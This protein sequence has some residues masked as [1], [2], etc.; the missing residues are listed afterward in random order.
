MINLCLD[1][2][3]FNFAFTA[4]KESDTSVQLPSDITVSQGSLSDQ[5]SVSEVSQLPTSTKTWAQILLERSQLRANSDTETTPRIL[6]EV[7]ISTYNSETVLKNLCFDAT[8]TQ[9]IGHKTISPDDRKTILALSS[10]LGSLHCEPKSSET[11][12]DESKM[13]S[14]GHP[15]DSHS[16]S[17]QVQDSSEGSSLANSELPSTN[18]FTKEL[19]QNHKELS[20]F[21]SRIIQ[22]SKTFHSEILQQSPQALPLDATDQ[23]LQNSTRISSPHVSTMVSLSPHC[24][25]QKDFTLVLHPSTV[26]DTNASA[27]GELT[28][29]ALFQL[30]STTNQSIMGHGPTLSACSPSIVDN[31]ANMTS[32]SPADADSKTNSSDASLISVIPQTLGAQAIT[33]S[34]TVDVSKTVKQSSLSPITVNSPLPFQPNYQANATSSVR[35]TANLK[36]N[37]FSETFFSLYHPPKEVLSCYKAAAFSV[38][39]EQTQDEVINMRT[40]SQAFIIPSSTPETLPKCHPYPLP[41]LSSFSESSHSPHVFPV[42]QNTANHKISADLISPNPQTSTSLS[43]LTQYSLLTTPESNDDVDISPSL[44][45]QGYLIQQAKNIP[46]SSPGNFLSSYYSVSVSE[47][48]APP[49]AMKA[50]A[51]VELSKISESFLPSVTTVFAA[52]SPS[53]SSSS[54][55]SSLIHSG[56]STLLQ[57]QPTDQIQI[58]TKESPSSPSTPSSTSSSCQMQCTIQMQKFLSPKVSSQIS[59]TSL[60]DNKDASKLNQSKFPESLPQVKSVPLLPVDHDQ[61]QSNKS[62]PPSENLSLTQYSYTSPETGSDKS[63]QPSSQINLLTSNHQLL[64][65]TAADVQEQKPSNFVVQRID[66]WQNSE[67]FGTNNDIWTSLAQDISMNQ[68]SSESGSFK[69][70]KSLSGSCSSHSEKQ[71]SPEVQLQIKEKS[72]TDSSSKDESPSFVPLMYNRN[73]TSSDSTD[74]TPEKVL[75]AQKSFQQT[76]DLDGAVAEVSSLIAKVS[77]PPELPDSHYSSKMVSSPDLSGLSGLSQLSLPS[78]MMEDYQHLIQQAR[79]LVK[80]CKANLQQEDEDKIYASG[81][82]CLLSG[83]PVASTQVLLSEPDPLT[84]KQSLL[85]SEDK[86]CKAATNK[87]TTEMRG[88][89]NFSLDQVSDFFLKLFVSKL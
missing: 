17:T 5:P 45:A 22:T 50:T 24:Q 61:P 58:Q 44:N 33:S 29:S 14:C 53:S 3:I 6:P 75:P 16:P 1:F 65:K 54:S 28:S 40:S 57:Y 2:S 59:S 52:P 79:T 32:T 60:P 89:P 66:S 47:G 56:P 55:P 78:D 70:T 18:S 64:Q 25:N 71:S 67:P 11:S 13:I 8:G 20:E 43:A 48:T 46:A 12:S 86:K 68:C 15:R 77:S 30:T 9:I 88:E 27:N 42:S 34:S 31:I 69:Y 73:T 51:G 84:D 63:L 26:S 19:L 74:T 72:S 83:M 41:Q 49:F 38:S 37:S 85:S 76:L 23:N 62:S 81:D 10:S 35:K 4:V 87:D 7:P 36:P 82:S 80:R 21:L 39:Q